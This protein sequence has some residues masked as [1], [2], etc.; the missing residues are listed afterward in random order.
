MKNFWEVLGDLVYK[1]LG[2]FAAYYKGKLDAKKEI[3]AENL[4]KDNEALKR[5]QDVQTNTDR[6]AAIERLR[7]LGKVRD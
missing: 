1:T 7:R 5:L 4:Q 2:V 6:D 3:K